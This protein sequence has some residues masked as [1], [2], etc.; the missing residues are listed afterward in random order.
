MKYRTC[1]AGCK[2]VLLFHR[3]NS[4]PNTPSYHHPTSPSHTLVTILVLRQSFM[5][6]L[7]S[8]GV[9]VQTV[10]GVL[11]RNSS[12]GVTPKVTRHH[13]DQRLVY[14]TYS[15]TLCNWSRGTFRYSIEFVYHNDHAVQSR[16]GVLR[17]PG[18]L[19]LSCHSLNSTVRGTRTGAK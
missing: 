10:L 7:Y 11:S 19:R 15:R 9:C 3:L 14:G 16:T 17:T 6:R 8:G 4:D 12:E 13:H 5:T 2:I 1:T 18:V